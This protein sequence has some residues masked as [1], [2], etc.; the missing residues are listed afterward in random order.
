MVLYALFKSFGNKM[1]EFIAIDVI[2]AGAF[3]L[4]LVSASGVDGVDGQ[5]QAVLLFGEVRW[6]V[7]RALFFLSIGR[8]LGK[9][10]QI[11]LGFPQYLLNERRVAPLW[12][13]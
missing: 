12:V 1:R 8:R 4:F 13:W 11:F 3:V 6:F 5:F 10:R 7:A 2:L 9:T